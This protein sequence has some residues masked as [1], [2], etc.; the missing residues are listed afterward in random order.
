MKHKTI[1]LHD[2]LKTIGE[3]FDEL[4]ET[5]HNLELYPN[6]KTLYQ[7]VDNLK[8]LMSAAIIN[9]VTCLDGFSHDEAHKRD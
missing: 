4:R 1:T 6:M 9:Q 7:H 5:H 2:C 8:T 3:T